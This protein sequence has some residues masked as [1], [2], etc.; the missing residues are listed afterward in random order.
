[1]IFSSSST[2]SSVRSRPV[3]CATPLTAVPGSRDV[4][5]PPS[6]VWRPFESD[7]PVVMVPQDVLLVALRYLSSIA[8]TR[9]NEV[10][11]EISADG[12]FPLT[13][14]HRDACMGWIRCSLHLQS[15]V[16]GPIN[17]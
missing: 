11:I 10:R 15:P 6:P 14:F 8:T 7:G 3:A 9:S 16:L 4:T 1:M 17:I 13:D 2:R 12:V 5:T